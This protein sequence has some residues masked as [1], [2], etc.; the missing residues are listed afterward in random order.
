MGFSCMISGRNPPGV[1]FDFHKSLDNQ[2]VSWIF[3]FYFRPA[4]ASFRSG[5]APRW[6]WPSPRPASRGLDFAFGVVAVQAQSLDV[7]RVIG[8]PLFQ[9]H[10]VVTLHR[11]PGQPLPLAFGAQ[12][13]GSEQLGPHRLQPAPG[14]ALGRIWAL[15]PYWL[16]M[17]GTA[18]A[19]IVD[20]G[21]A[22][23]E[24][25]RAWGGCRHGIH[26]VEQRCADVCTKHPTRNC[27]GWWLIRA[28][29]R[30][31]ISTNKKAHRSGQAPE[32]NVSPA[33][34]RIEIDHLFRC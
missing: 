5:S 2:S 30:T 29:L 22:S 13:I 6:G 1:V 4:L 32:T 33:I 3:R 19:A 12:W 25:A 17:R 27:L 10:D 26:Q 11:R 18:A 9:R 8:A 20:Q 24:R 15:S 31:I 7:A 14:D 34:E 28:L 21:A 23:G 16:R